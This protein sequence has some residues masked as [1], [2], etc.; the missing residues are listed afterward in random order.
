MLDSWHYS[1]IMYP[2]FII[3]ICLGI[4]TYYKTREVWGLAMAVFGIFLIVKVCLLTRYPLDELDFVLNIIQVILGAWAVGT[5]FK[6][7]FNG[8]AEEKNSESE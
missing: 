3:C 5:Y 2:V 4:R 7:R 6:W 1:P 8:E